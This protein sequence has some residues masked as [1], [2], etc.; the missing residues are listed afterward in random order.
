MQ[1]IIPMAG[2]GTRFVRAGFKTIKPLIEVDGR[3]MIEHV[4]RMFPGEHKFLFICAQPHLEETPLRSVLKSLAPNAT[5]VGIKP[6]KGGPLYTALAAA[7]YI[8]DGEPVILNY[9]DAA[10]LWH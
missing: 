10:A 4:V 3:P 9:C 1:I 6:H 2:S 5:I 8:K 7:D